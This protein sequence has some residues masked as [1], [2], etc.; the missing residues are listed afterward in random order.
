MKVTLKNVRLSFPQLF[1]AKGFNGGEENKKFSATFILDKDD[2]ADLI[3]KVKSVIAKVKKEK[4]GKDAGK[5]KKLCL[6]DG[7]EKE[8][9]DGYDDTVMAISSSTAKRPPVVDRK[10]VPVTEEDDKVYAGCFV[11]ATIDIWAQ[12]NQYGKRV[13]A[14]LRAVQFWAD[15]DAFGADPVD[16]EQEFEA[17][18]DDD[19]LGELEG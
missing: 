18:E 2:H 13:N 8:E 3:E 7:E 16:A 14:Q 10:L 6:I 11:N 12:D 1:T 19:D 4:W 5:V 17:A 9:F 15:G